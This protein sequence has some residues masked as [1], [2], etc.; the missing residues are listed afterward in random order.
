MRDVRDRSSPSLPRTCSVLNGPL[1]R[2]CR[3]AED[4]EKWEACV[5]YFRRPYKDAG[6]GGSSSGPALELVAGQ[7]SPGSSASTTDHGCAY[8]DVAC[9]WPAPPSSGS[10]FG[11]RRRHFRASP[12]GEMVI[13]QAVFLPRISLRASNVPPLL[14]YQPTHL[15]QFV[16]VSVFRPN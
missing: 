8:E 16:L 12:S 3:L 1:S 4:I 10:F 7:S 2:H 14:R 15:A 9:E 6:A 11:K 13:A 5:V